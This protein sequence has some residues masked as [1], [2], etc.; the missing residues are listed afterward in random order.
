MT[1]WNDEKPRAQIGWQENSDKKRMLPAQLNVSGPG[2]AELNCVPT[3]PL[4]DGINNHPRVEVVR[5]KL[6]H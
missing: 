2:I 3:Y 1:S 4:T 5:D 6:R